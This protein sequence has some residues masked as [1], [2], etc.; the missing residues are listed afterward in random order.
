MDLC[1]SVKK[2]I[3][4]LKTSI[5]VV[6]TDPCDRKPSVNPNSWKQNKTKNK[7]TK[8][9]P[10]LRLKTHEEQYNSISSQ[11]GQE[12]LPKE[13]NKMVIIGLSSGVPS[14]QGK[15]AVARCHSSWTCLD[16]ELYSRSSAR[17]PL[18]QSLLQFCVHTRPSA[19]AKQTISWN[20]LPRHQD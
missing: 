4:L 13:G 6:I 7:Q 3:V 15:S 2:R 5:G 14:L 20:N 16:T 11:R 18:S 1:Y 10:T 8:K 19:L 17:S 12:M 9:K